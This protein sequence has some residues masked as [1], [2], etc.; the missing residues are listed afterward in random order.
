[1][2]KQTTCTILANASKLGYDQG[3]GNSQVT[4][5][6]TIHTGNIRLQIKDENANAVSEAN[7][8]STSQPSGMSSLSGI[9]DDAGYIVFDSVLEGSYTIQI[10]KSGYDTKNETISVTAGQTTERTISLSNTPSPWPSTP[11]LIAT[12]AIVIIA[13]AMIALVLRKY[14]ISLSTKESTNSE[15]NH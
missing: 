14:R 4:V 2:T 12:I 5:I 11:T 6:S 7:I 8:T 15:K 9:T 13:I 10:A 1:M 3:Q